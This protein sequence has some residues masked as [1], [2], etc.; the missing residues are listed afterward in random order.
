MAVDLHLAES[1][2]KKLSAQARSQL[3]RTDTGSRDSFFA[4]HSI[5]EKFNCV[6]ADLSGSNAIAFGEV[7]DLI[8]DDN[9]CSTDEVVFH[10]EYAVE[11]VQHL[12]EASGASGRQEATKQL[13]ADRH[14]RAFGPWKVAGPLGGGGQS[15]TFTVYPEGKSPDHVCVLKDLRTHDAKALARFKREIDACTKLDHG[16][17]IKVVDY[18]LDDSRPYMVTEYCDRGSLS[19]YGQLKSMPTIERLKLYHAICEAVAC[20]HSHGIVHRDLKPE[21]I[22]VK[23]DGTPVVGDFGI[24]FLEGDGVRFTS[25]DEGVGPRRFIPPEL[26]DGLL[27]DVKPS[28]DVYMLGGLLYWLLADRRPPERKSH[29]HPDWDLQKKQPTTGMTLVN[30]LLDKMMAQDPGDRLQSGTE[31]VKEVESM[32]QRL[33][34]DGRPTDLAV[35]IRCVWC[36]MGEYH[37]L[38][39][40]EF[41]TNRPGDSHELDRFG[42][43]SDNPN[44]RNGA[45]IILACKHCGNVQV[46]RPDFMSARNNWKRSPQSKP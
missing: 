28:S 17:I 10:I 36:E 30:A 34:A 16:N 24:C 27:E 18:N 38:V 9:H 32:I 1:K 29:R 41:V 42:F 25:I 35:P 7:V 14:E 8:W 15:Q 11:I 45:W 44:G 20:A 19:D 23:S 12:L 2:L 21:N 13:L 22:F 5:V 4:M 26:A 6:L 31:V 39:D 40:D 43:K 3:E 37:V 46:F 33:E